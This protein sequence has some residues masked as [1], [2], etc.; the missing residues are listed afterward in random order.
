MFEFMKSYLAV[1]LLFLLLFQLVPAK[2]Y[3]K[4]IRFFM[5]ILLAFVFLSPV[6]SL[7]MNPEEFLEKVQ[8]EAF[9]EE[10]E[11]INQNAKKIEFSKQSEY[12][13]QYKKLMEHEIERVAAAQ[14]FTVKQLEI[15]L[16]KQYEV[17]HISLTVT[18]D[19]SHQIIIGKIEVG[20]EREQT[21][22]ETELCKNLK[23]TL[24][25]HYG[26]SEE[27]LDISYE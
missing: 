10:A 22:Q 17:S 3:Q 20:E 2:T 14:N 15:E 25:E 18:G 23:E 27:Q 26:L 4:Y 16:T 24:M 13:E 7:F 9:L 1:F 8:Y 12:F 11:E 19:A 5:G 21:P 6:L